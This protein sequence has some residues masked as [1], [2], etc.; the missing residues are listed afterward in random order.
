MEKNLDLSLASVYDIQCDRDKTLNSTITCT[1]I[2]ITGTTQ[3][4]DFSSYSGAT[5]TIKNSAGTVL[6]LFSTTD[7]SITLYGNTG[8]FKLLKTSAEMDVIRSGQ[9][10]YDMILKSAVYPKRAFLRGKI[11]FIQN[12]TN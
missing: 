4:F 8:K 5:I 11:F 9:Y 7:G 1:Y 12:I 10:N 6:M 3:L 2:D